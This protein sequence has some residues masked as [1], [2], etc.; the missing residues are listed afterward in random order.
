MIPMNTPISLRFGR[1]ACLAGVLLLLFS[2]DGAAGCWMLYDQ[3]FIASKAPIIVL[4][5]VVAIDTAA[6]RTT[7][8]KTARYLDGA[9]IKVEKVYKNTLSDVTVEEKGEITAFMH[10][11]NGAI[12]GSETKDGKAGVFRCSTDLRYEVRTRAVWFVFLGADGKLYVNKHPQ[13]CVALKKED[14]A[15]AT[16]AFGTTNEKVSRAEWARKDRSNLHP[17]D[18][19]K[20]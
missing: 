5:E 10:S 12:P 13:Q 8:H 14:K 7:E 18:R 3:G 15:P 1:V 2:R 4:G 6:A 9:R 11:T 17:Q 20:Q 16:G 19:Q